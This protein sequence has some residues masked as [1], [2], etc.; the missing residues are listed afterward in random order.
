MTPPPPLP[1]RIRGLTLLLAGVSAAAVAAPVHAQSTGVTV[2]G[3][4]IGDL[5]YP[6][7][8]VPGRGGEASAP[9][10]TAEPFPAAAEPAE[11]LDVPAPGFD[12]PIISDAEFNAAIP[13][14]D[15][16]LESLADF[17]ARTR[18]GNGAVA[19][20]DGALTLPPVTGSIDPALAALPALQDGS[21]AEAIA[22]ST[23]LD[24]AL[25]EPLPPL[26][27]FDVTPVEVPGDAGD[28]DTQVA[29][30]TE[31]NGLD[32][33]EVRTQFDQLSALKDGDGEAANAAQVD[34]RAREDA[35]LL[36]RIL[37]AQG[38]YA[39]TTSVDVQPRD[40]GS[41]R[42]VLTAKPGERYT[43]SSVTIDGPVAE[44]AG[45]AR[46]E[47]PLA[48]GDPIDAALVQ[49]AEANLAVAL[50]RQGY[51]FANLGER[52]ILL[53]D[54]DATGAYTLPL[55]LGPRASFGGIRT[56]GDL[57]FDARHVGVLTRFEA[58]Q[59]Y[60]SRLTDDLRQALVATSLFSAV[61]VEP[62]RTGEVLA[63]GT[64]R[65]DLLVTQDAGP[66][67]Q[68]AA[69]V[70]YGTG[71]GFRV[72]GSWTHRNLFPP[73]GAL[74]ATGVLGT[75]EQA[76]G[77]AFKRS[78]AGKRDRTVTLLAQVSHSNFNAFEAFT[79]TLAGNIARVST[80]IW[81][82]RFTY[83]YGFELT[84]TN[85]QDYDFRLG[86][87]DR[88]TFF[89]GALPGQVGFDTSDDLLNPTRGYRAL[90]RVSPEVSLGRGTNPYGRV[91]VEGSTYY[92]IG[93]S[94]VLAGR[95][96]LG[97]I[98]GID[99]QSLAPSRRYYGGGG[100][101]VRGFGFQELGPKDPNDDPIGG[102]SLNEAAFE[103]RYR[104]GNF[105]IVPFVDVGQVYESAIPD[106]SSLR[107]GVGIGGR[108]Y[109][110]FGPF[111][112]DVATPLGRKD[113]ES[114]VSVYVSIGQAF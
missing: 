7:A 98:Q 106:F 2:R 103:V 102:R 67:R 108:F 23:A 48:A 64:E 45:L 28:G 49:A 97:T 85:E 80:P 16:P 96:R 107:A 42:V 29:Y 92:P 86:K 109:T 62:V 94:I 72:E 60:D 114:A 40:D 11:P 4:P 81:Q 95:V 31:L 34:A 6:E 9:E 50:P 36:G 82:K 21:S 30:S 110:N 53:A 71:Q 8:P 17:D 15:A 99:R 73:E 93:E 27:A 33:A 65:V 41:L 38:Y 111:R 25:A 47:L 44:P 58:G 26:A 22:D 113:G 12:D 18:S 63:D 74:T 68:L 54:A 78:N 112:V 75:Q 100:G 20:Q 19:A 51:P 59:L 52:D 89:I 10:R 84:G 24:P 104:F 105:G 90:V 39:A 69:A 35:A 46:R 43:F 101:S 77:V 66:A 83:A 79:G 14:L 32:V 56:E 61:S 37:T 76:L 5:I 91:L 88:Q 55:E 1:A 13:A 87:R 70:G 3:V 57:A